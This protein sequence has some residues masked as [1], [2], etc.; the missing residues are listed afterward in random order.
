MRQREAQL[1]FAELEF[2]RQ[3]VQLD[4]ALRR[5]SDFLDAHPELSQWVQADLQRGL[6]RPHTGRRGLTGEQVLRA[7][8]LWRI[9]HWPYREL[10]SRIA[11]GYTLRQF[12]RVGAGPVPA[13]DAFQRSFARMNPD[14][15]RRI[16]DALIRAAVGLKLEDG[17]QLRVDT[18]VVESDIHYPSDSALL[19]DGIRTITRLVLEHLAPKLAGVAA[20]FPDRRRRARRRMQ[21]LSRMHDRRGKH[22]RSFRRKY[23]DL[24]TVASEVTARAKV[25]IEQARRMAL[26]GSAEQLLINA[27]CEEIIHYTTLTERVIDQTRRRIFAGEVVPAE[28]K[29]YSLFEPHTDLI[30]RGKA[31]KPVEFGHK[32]FLAESRGGLITDYRVLRGNPPDSDQVAGSLDNHQRL[33]ARAPKLYAADRGFDHPAARTLCENTGVVE[34][35]IPQRGGKLGAARAATQH[36][37]RFKAGQRYRA[38]IEGT[39]SVL[40]RG[41]G[42]RRCLLEG[43]IRFELLVGASVLAANLLRLA[44]LLERRSRK[45]KP[46]GAPIARAA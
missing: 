22:E 18:T 42:M 25:V 32:V 16:N 20:D 45:R 33:F 7:L 38:G 46:P 21:E 27:L 8:L 17:A 24:L 23:R 35:C 40:L 14:T 26:N 10:R 6:K 15:I 4:P 11:D 2:E 1:S 5:I 30:K 39:I 3:R 43:P 44:T 28:Q 37:R 19:W 12:T 9:K 29:L 13:A 41:R 34:L 31:R 36:S